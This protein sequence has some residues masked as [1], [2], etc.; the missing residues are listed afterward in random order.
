MKVL[1]LLAFLFVLQG[2]HARATEQVTILDRAGKTSCPSIRCVMMQ[3]LPAPPG[4]SSRIYGLIL[5][6]GFTDNVSIT[7]LDSDGAFVFQCVLEQ[8]VG[9][10]PHDP[11]ARGVIFTIRADH[12]PKTWIHMTTEKDGEKQGYEISLIL[13][14]KGEP[15]ERKAAAD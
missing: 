14:P 11:E 12:V 5:P 9:I 8:K 1:F 2:A 10:F 6:A 7:V 3:E 4:P 15:A 13:P